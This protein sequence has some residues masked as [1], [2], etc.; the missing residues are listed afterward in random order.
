MT[1]FKQNKN[2]PFKN[3]SLHTAPLNYFSSELLPSILSI[4]ILVS[5]IERINIL[6]VQKIAAYL[7]FSKLLLHLGWLILDRPWSFV[8]TSGKVIKCLL[9]FEKTVVVITFIKAWK[10]LTFTMRLFFTDQVICFNCGN[11][12]FFYIS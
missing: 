1:F 4:P 11:V 2:C 12:F 10:L 5:Y 6:L 7:Y 3:L 8:P 9:P